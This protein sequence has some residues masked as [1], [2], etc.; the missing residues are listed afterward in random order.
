VAAASGS[1]Q[2]GVEA[3][4]HFFTPAC[5]SSTSAGGVVERGIDQ[6]ALAARAL[7]FGLGIEGLGLG[8]EGEAQSL[9]QLGAHL[10][11]HVVVGGEGQRLLEHGARH[12]RGHAQGAFGDFFGEQHGGA[13]LVAFGQAEVGGQHM[14]AQFERERPVADVDGPDQHRAH[15]VVLYR[16]IGG[17][18]ACDPRAIAADHA[19]LGL[20]LALDRL[21]RAQEARSCPRAASSSAYSLA[22][23][24]VSGMAAGRAPVCPALPC[25]RAAAPA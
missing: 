10:I 11:G 8:L 15:D 12:G 22:T 17:K 2:V 5:W 14:V 23:G 6:R 21:D 18:R 19:A 25:C 7:A 16:R 9:V 20:D 24:P 3:L 1:F 4:D 13:A